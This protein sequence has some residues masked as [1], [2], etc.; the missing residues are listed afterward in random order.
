[1]KEIDCSICQQPITGKY[2]GNCGQSHT[3]RTVTLFTIFY[4]FF[5]NLFSLEKSGFSTIIYTLKTPKK[6]IDNYYLGFRN[7][8]LS[9]GKILIYGVITITLH[10]TLVN[11]KVLGLIV[12]LEQVNA[13]YFFWA[14]LFPFLILSSYATFFRTKHNFSKHIISTIYLATSIFIALTILNDIL[15]LSIGDVF[16]NGVFVIFSALVFGYN[17]I[18]FTRKRTFIWFALN[19]IIQLI[20]FALLITLLLISINYV[21]EA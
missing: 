9:P 17:S 18:V 20:V 6:V 8:Y 4:D 16:K 1:M 2:C 21:I 19:S 15:I 5:S 3:G 7:Y 10:V 13:E 12:E 11:E 14:I